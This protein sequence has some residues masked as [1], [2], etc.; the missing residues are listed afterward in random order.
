MAK[1]VSAKLIET[2]TTDSYELVDNFSPSMA[3]DLDTIFLWT[4]NQDSS[5]HKYRI[6]IYW[7]SWEKAVVIITEINDDPSKIIA[8]T[9]KELVQFVCEL[10]KLIPEKI[11]WVEHYAP[12]NSN[13]KDTYIQVLLMNAKAS[14]YKLEP[15]KLE[16]LIG[17]PL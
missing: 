9:T 11:M 7:I 3:D 5:E 6:R 1:E 16:R 15:E 14:R 13:D 12:S 8:K 10:Y 2:S 17:I 4:S